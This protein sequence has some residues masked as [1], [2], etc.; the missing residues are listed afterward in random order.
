MSP[1][2]GGAEQRVHRRVQHD[3]GVGV[4]CESRLPVEDDPAEHERT[5]AAEAVDVEAGSD[6]QVRCAGRPAPCFGQVIA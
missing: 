5:A 4:S 3:V 1:K 2:A 6:P